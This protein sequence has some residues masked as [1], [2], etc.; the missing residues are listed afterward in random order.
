[1]AKKT[2]TK[3]SPA[4]AT[5]TR[6]KTKKEFD[7]TV[8]GATGFTGGLTAEYL[9]ANAPT[10]LKLALAGRNER[11]LQDA[12][13]RMQ[14]INPDV[15]AELILCDTADMESLEGMTA[16]SKV[17]ATTV[18]PYAQYGEPLVQACIKTGTDYLDITGEPEYVNR[19]VEKYDEAA[20]EAGV[21][22]INCC[23]FDS[24]PAD[25]GALFAASQLPADAP[26]S[27]KGFVNSQ[28]KPSGGTW[29]SAINA[30][31]E[32][33][34]ED[35]QSNLSAGGL[36]TNFHKV[37]E[38]DAW[39]IPMPVIDPFI[40][41]RSARVR[42]D[43]YGPDFK[44][45]QFIAVGSLLTVG[46]LG[47]GV[48]GIFL[49]AQLKPT[50]DLLLNVFKQGEGPSEEER[51]RSYFQ[52]IFI[53]E[54]GEEQVITRVSGGDPGYTETAKMLAESAMIFL[55]NKKQAPIKGGVTTPAG[56]MGMALVNRLNEKGIKF[57][58]MTP[59]VRL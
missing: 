50:R 46:M 16:R 22:I 37:D 3:K 42:P 18:G 31:S 34:F 41:A 29:A 25:L 23:G 26:R 36:E 1:M 56:A 52:V 58:V 47:I 54:A 9:A 8:F 35:L 11:K 57:E 10:K 24:I 20:R 19:L 39:A 28:G 38:L 14:R 51:A 4:K 45:G 13:A 17:V 43:E 27:V 44:Y 6:S 49:G 55:A 5:A 48:G 32:G 59:P 7:I 53:A 2:T 21:F 12:L 15:E 40:V 30:M 33:S